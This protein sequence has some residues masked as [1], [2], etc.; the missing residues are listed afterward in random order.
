M[1]RYEQLLEKFK[2][3]DQ[4]H[5]DVWKLF[6]RFT[7]EMIRR[8]FK[9]Y[10]VKSVIERIRWHTSK[11]DVKGQDVF[12]IGNNH[13]PFYAR[14]FIVFY[15]EYASFFRTRE[16]ISKRKGASELPEL[17]PSDFPY[18]NQS[19]EDQLFINFNS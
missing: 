10:G 1:T 5:P 13:A 12:K 19:D 7:F 16:Q 3:Y 2:E 8:G 18:T 15:P 4:Q 11:P 6:V 9:H 14:K 17:R